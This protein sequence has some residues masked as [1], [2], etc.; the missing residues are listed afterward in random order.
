MITELHG[1]RYYIQFDNWDTCY[2]I[3]DEILNSDVL[4]DEDFCI[5]KIDGTY[6]IYSESKCGSFRGPKYHEWE[7]IKALSY[8]LK[9]AKRV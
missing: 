9:K 5:Q 1:K 2:R 6:V 8:T 3:F 4:K 7:R